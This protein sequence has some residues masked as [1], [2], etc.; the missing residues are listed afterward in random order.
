MSLEWL[1]ENDS[2]EAVVFSKE[3]RGGRSAGGSSKLLPTARN[4]RVL[5]YENLGPMSRE[6]GIGHFVAEAR[7][8]RQ[9]ADA[10]ASDVSRRSRTNGKRRCCRCTSHSTQ[11]NHRHILSKHLLPRFGEKAVAD[12]TRRRFRRTSLI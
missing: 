6:G 3:E 12:V 2:T 7:R 11:K 9:S 4:K 8:S 5:R 10:I 1:N